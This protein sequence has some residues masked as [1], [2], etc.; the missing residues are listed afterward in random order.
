MLFQHCFSYIVLAIAPVLM[1]LECLLP[2]LCTEFFQSHWLLS[3]ITFVERIMTGKRGMNPVA[4]SIINSQKKICSA[5]NS[6]QES[7]L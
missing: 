3:L 5:E 1:F 6:N 2:I 4:L 7:K